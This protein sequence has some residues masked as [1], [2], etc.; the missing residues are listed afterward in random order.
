MSPRAHHDAFEIALYADDL[1]LAKAHAGN[2]AEDATLLAIASGRL[3]DV[4]SQSPLVT[5]IRQS[6]SGL[7]PSEGLT[8]L[9]DDGR[10]GEAL[11]TAIRQLA[12][13]DE[14]DPKAIGDGL[15]LLIDLGQR[16]WA[17]RIAI[18]LLL[19]EAAA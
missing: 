8:R 4:R 1:E 2:S 15:S 3:G 14:G 19:E 7:P 9:M 18:E 12:E 13:G 5:A 17:R 11:L 6:L 10:R 16:E